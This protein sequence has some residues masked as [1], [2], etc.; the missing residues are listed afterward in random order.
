MQLVAFWWMTSHAGGNQEPYMNEHI[1]KLLNGD[2]TNY[3]HALEQQFPRILDKI[4]ELWDMPD[5]EAYFHELMV[6]TRGGTRQ[7]LPPAVASDIFFLHNTYTSQLVHPDTHTNVW[8]H[9][10]ELKKQEL[11][12]LGYT[13]SQESFLNAIENGSEAAVKVFLSCGIDVDVRD[14]REWTPLMISSFN[15][16]EEMA[17]FLIRCG[18]KIQAEDRNGYTPLHWSAFNGY[19]AVV[20]ILLQKGAKINARS[21]FGWT[22]LMQ[23][24]TRGHTQAVK[25]LLAHGANVNETTSDGWTALHKAA[26]NGHGEVVLMLLEKGASRSIEY[27]DGSTAL[28]LATKN[29]HEKVARILT[30]YRSR[31]IS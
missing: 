23:A 24:A 30:S 7:G 28:S 17:L 27:P 25:T 31:H 21:Q 11:E 5:V 22:A 2:E 8:A 12:Q 6:D 16:N 3:P 29:K 1:L 4:L 20:E 14:E 26:A 15:G 10:P 18:A 9:I 19:T 13:F